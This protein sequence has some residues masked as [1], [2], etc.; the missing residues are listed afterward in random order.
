MSEQLEDIHDPYEV[1]ADKTRP[2]IDLELVGRAAS[3]SVYSAIQNASNETARSQQQQDH[4]IGVSNLGHCQ[5]YAVLM[6]KQTPFSDERD[7]TPAF[8][9]TVAGEAIEQQLRIDHP[10][11]HIQGDAFFTLPSGGG[12]DGHFDIVIPKEAGCTY[13]ELVASM[14]E[15][16]DGPDVA[17][18][19][20]W[21]LKSKAE[22]ETIRKYGPSRQQIWQIHAYTSA[23]IDA[24]LLDPTKPIILGD[25][26]FDRSGK[27]LDPYSVF[28]LYDPDVI[29]FIDE[30]VNGVKY[31]VMNGEEGAK[32]MERDWCFSW[33]E[34]ATIC[35]GT[36]T[37]VE[38][39]ITNPEVLTAVEVYRE[40]LDMENAGKKKKEA[41]K[42]LLE[43]VSGSTGTYNVRNTW[44][45]GG[46]V[47]YERAGY[48]K[49]EVRPV[50]K[51]KPA[52]KVRKKKAVEE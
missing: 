47:S 9:G 32:E 6:V 3:L 16:Y 2:D 8:F 25:V 11:W 24:G 12:I 22:L 29:G 26:Y 28:H 7:K 37:D 1:F 42:H 40:G 36:D 15:D 31:A 19:G 46:A 48:N 34:Y 18:Q 45:N 43:G 17:M 20:V 33:C 38:G 41:V 4:F 14:E 30:W 51:S 49:I 35:R 23:A 52:P 27:T 5:N 44:V 13:E 10:D 50:P 39:L 21:D